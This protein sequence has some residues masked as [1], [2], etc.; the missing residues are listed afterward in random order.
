[1]QNV[2]GLDSRRDLVGADLTDRGKHR[3][4][5]ENCRAE[6]GQS[7]P[8]VGSSGQLDGAGAGQ[9]CAHKRGMTRRRS[10]RSRRN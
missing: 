2:A 3:G 6:A 9:P 8:K 7:G 4:R 1:M 5:F 10:R